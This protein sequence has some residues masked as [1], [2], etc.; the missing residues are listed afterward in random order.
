LTFSF[1]NFRSNQ[2]P[3]FST[4]GPLVDEAQEVTQEVMAKYHQG[5]ADCGSTVAFL[6]YY[7]DEESD[8]PALTVRGK[9][10]RATIANTPLK[11]RKLGVPD[12][13]ISIDADWWQMATRPQQEAL[14]DH[15][16]SHRDP[17]VDQ[18]G[19]VVRDDADRPKFQSVPHDHHIGTFTSVVQHY[20][21]ASSELE[22]IREFDEHRR[23]QW[24]FAECEDEDED[25]PEAHDV[26]TLAMDRKKAAQI[27]RRMAGA[28]R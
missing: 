10:C 2:V 20:G 27:S 9:K 12:L 25:D 19:A 15:E 4:K 22:L 28:S 21:E 13:Q 17:R 16:L 3:N 6:M 5:L 1:L 7:A 23:Q 26:G 8:Q 14:L 24:Q 11:Y 18:E